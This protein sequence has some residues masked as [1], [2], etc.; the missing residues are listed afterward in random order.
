MVWRSEE[1]VGS[2]GAVVTAVMTHLTWVLGTDLGASA[3]TV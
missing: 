1:I 2:S 3:R